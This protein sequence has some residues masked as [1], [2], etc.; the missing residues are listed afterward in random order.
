MKYRFAALVLLVTAVAA[1]PIALAAPPVLT[2]SWEAARTPDD[3]R[4]YLVLKDLGKAEIVAEYD[5]AIPG[6]AP[7]RSR[8]T[9]FG[10]W[11]LKGNEVIVTYAN[12]QDRLRYVGSQSLAAIGLGGTA[13]ALKPVGKPDP[14]SRIGAAILWKAPHDYRLKAP[15]GE[16]QGKP[17]PSPSKP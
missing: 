17:A 2:G 11:T 14:K 3:E 15:E 5:L 12:I 4:L 9:S 7:K 16:Q 1:T 10:K 6:Q 8:S 13:P